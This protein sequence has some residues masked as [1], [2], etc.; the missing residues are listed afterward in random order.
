MKHIKNY[1]DVLNESLTSDIKSFL[2]GKTFHNKKSKMFL[3]H[4]T[5]IHPRDFILNS[6]YEGED[7]EDWY[8][9]LPL[10]FIFLSTSIKEATAY[11]QYIIPCELSYYD[12]I[13]FKVNTDNPSRA[14]DMD[15]G[16]DLFK[17]DVQH[18][19]WIKFEDSGKSVLI[20]KGNK[21]STYITDYSNVI[22]RTDL[23]QEFYKK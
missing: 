3:Y 1:K 20:I 5:D 11:G 16:I 12:H 23:A 7:S 9:Y 10:G 13:S 18:N 17:P 4:G 21:K 6:E 15:Y 2:K 14:F 22:P 19:Y 8:D